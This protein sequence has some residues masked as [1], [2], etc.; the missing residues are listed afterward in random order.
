M[1]QEHNERPQQDDEPKPAYN[2]YQTQ[3]GEVLRAFGLVSAIGIDLAICVIGGSV[4][5]WWLDKQWGTTPWML[6]LG[7]V[8]GLGAGVYGVVKLIQNFGPE[9]QKKKDK[10]T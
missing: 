1:D 4:T 8:V 7:I 5:G 2:P 10:S 3:S 9:A 6:L